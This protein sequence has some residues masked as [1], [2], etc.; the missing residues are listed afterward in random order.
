MK[1]A[2]PRRGAMKCARTYSCNVL[3]GGAKIEHRMS[4]TECRM[5]KE[6]V[7]ISRVSSKSFVRIY[8]DDEGFRFL[9][10]LNNS[11]MFQPGLSQEGSYEMREDLFIVTY[12]TKLNTEYR[13]PNIECRRS[14]FLP[15]AYLVNCLCC[16]IVINGKLIK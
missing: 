10:C 12:F 16:S 11:S 14:A 13:T 4:N 3:S 6:C 1:H 7:F 9:I 2:G 15:L 8:Y 5:S